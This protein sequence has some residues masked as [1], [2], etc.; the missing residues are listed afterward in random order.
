[1]NTLAVPAA[2]PRWDAGTRLKM[3]AKIASVKKAVPDREDHGAEET[4]PGRR[5]DAV[6]S[7]P[8]REVAPSDAAASRIGGARS[9]SVR[10][11]DPAGDDDDPEEGRA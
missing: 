8:T 4:G 6:I 7:S 1:M 9:G 10:E 3:A 2:L 11:Q 5:N